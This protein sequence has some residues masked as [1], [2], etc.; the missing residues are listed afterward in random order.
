MSIALRDNIKP[1][2]YIK[3]NAAAMLRY[4]NEHKNPM[5]IT[6]N[7][8]AK[9]VVMDIET[10]QQNEDALAMLSILRLAE[11]DCAKGLEYP[12]DEVF[13][14]IQEEID[15]IQKE[16]EREKEENA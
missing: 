14:R 9:A 6:Q 3:S 13:D 15:E 16:K 1:I 11:D 7:G 5:I 12:V 10:Y 4:V 2:S 8:E